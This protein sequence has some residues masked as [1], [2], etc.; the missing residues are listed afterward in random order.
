MEDQKKPEI[1]V[2]G[3]LLV[4]IVIFFLIGFAVAFGI[5]VANRII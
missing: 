5:S 1:G 2:V 3:Q 4:G